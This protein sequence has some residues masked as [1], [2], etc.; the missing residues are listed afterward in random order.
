VLVLV[1]TACAYRSQGPVV[2]IDNPGHCVP[3]DVAAAPDTAKLLT[4]IAAQFNGSAAARLPDRAC[5][6]VRIETVDSPVALR[7]LAGSWPSAPTLGP[8]P[9]VWVPGSSVWGELLDARLADRHLRQIASAGTPFA[10][11]PLVIAMPAPMAK[12]LGYPK[13]PVAWTDIA[14]LAADARGWAAYGHP[15][16]GPFRLG[17]GN[18]NW[19]TTGL[20]QTVALAASNPAA[21]VSRALEQSVVYYGDSTDAYL[22]NWRRLAATAAPSDALG[23]L[24]AAITDE[25]SVVKYDEG[26]AQSNE[27]LDAHAT[28][29]NLPLVPI[30]PSDATIAGDNPIIV[31]RA[32][33]SSPS[34][35]AGA[36]QFRAFALQPAAQA[37]V[38][39][40][41][42]R[43]ARGAAR[44]DLLKPAFGIDLGARTDS[45]APAP[46]TIERA[47]TAWA[48]DRR[49]GRVLVLF[50]VSDSMGDPLPGIAHGPSKMVVARTALRGALDQLASGD[51]I[52]LRIFTTKLANP[53]S[54]NWLD[55]VPTGPLAARGPALDTAIAALTP[56]LGSPLYAA[57]RD[58]FDAVVRD[59]DPERINGVVVLTDGYNEDKGDTNLG[60]LLAHLAGHP[61]VRVFTIEYSNQAD[62]TTLPEIAQATNA[63]T[64]DATQTLDL[65]DVFARALANF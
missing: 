3:V 61:D 11:T 54:P 56:R 60:A 28:N 27:N 43:P 45:V 18:P 26:H 12:A 59:A 7:E 9:A 2:Q 58:A 5:A 44:S 4:D 16:W 62:T 40:A 6:F 36:R 50:D 8:A 52:G 15:E 64:Y 53:V 33:W 1:S 51:D 57:T 17:K 19:S 41:G 10:R 31:L 32:P 48:A 22:D 25:R 42:F 29:R 34:A 13:R 65:P 46:A 49:P 24:S 23:Y 14:Q 39:A 63:W 37:K 55:V 47:L 35:Q 20:D 38:A 30:Y 21:S